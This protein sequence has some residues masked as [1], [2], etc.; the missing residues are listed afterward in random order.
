MFYISA[1]RKHIRESSK[2]I[3]FVSFW[4][5]SETIEILM[6]AEIL[7]ELNLNPELPAD[8]K[9]VAIEQGENDDVKCEL[10]EQL[11]NLIFEKGEFTAHRTDD[12]FLTKFLRARYWNVDLTF[13]L[14]SN[15]YSFRDANTNLH[16]NVLC[17]KLMSLAE[18]EIITVTPY[19]EQNGRRIMILRLGI[20]DPSKMPIDDILRLTLIIL[21]LGAMEP[22]SQ[23][24]GGI[25]I[26]D[27]SGLTLNHVRYLTPSIAQKIIALI[28]TSS[29]LRTA[30]IHI[31][32]QSWIFGAIIK[33]F[34]PFLNARMK[35]KLFVHGSDMKSLHKHIGPNYLPKRYDGVLEN[36]HFP[37]NLWADSL[38]TN[39]KVKWELEK[40]GYDTS[41]E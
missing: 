10:I 38:R 4:K 22:I 28:V 36:S 29:P 2:K 31:V 33:V 12:E 21:E 34:T 32:N 25:G 26:F 24:S 20:W 6:A 35:E 11:R 30:A 3:K 1:T 8:V 41:E 27:L 9:K 5:K 39:D 23:V 15:Y 19:R 16:E 40:L 13:K 14:L 18:Q 7:H 17:V 37:L